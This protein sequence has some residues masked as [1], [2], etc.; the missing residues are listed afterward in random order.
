M[1][2]QPASNAPEYSV[3][4]I[5]SA[6]KRTVEDAFG[7]VRV[8]GELGRV[9]RP[10]SGHVYTDLK[11][12]RAVLSA[13]MWKGTASKLTFKPKEGLEVI[14]TGRMTTFQGQSRYQLVIDRIEPAGVGALMKLLE[15][16]RRKLAAEGLFDDARKRDLPFL[17]KVIG[18]VTSPTG[19]VIRDILHRLSDRTPAHVLVWPVRVQG[20]T[21]AAEVTRAIDGFNAL[22]PGGAIPRPDVL[23]VARGGGS[24]ED[25]WGFNEENV[26]RA[27]AASEIPLVSAVGHETDWTLI[28]YAADVRAPTPTGAAEMVVPVRADLVLTVDDLARRLTA[29]AL[30]GLE[31]RRR[32]LRIAARALP[33]AETLLT[34]PRQRLDQATLRL[35]QALES[36]TLRQRSRFDR[37]ASRLTPRLVVA[38]IKER[39]RKAK[40][41][42]DRLDRAQRTLRDR[43]AERLRALSARVTPRA[44]ERLSAQGNRQLVQ[45]DGRRERAW[46]S[47]LQMRGDRLTQSA[48]LL[49][50][51]NYRRVLDR[52]FALVR[53]QEG[54]PLRSVAQLDAAAQVSIEMADGRR[55][56]AVGGAPKTE[57]PAKKAKRVTDARPVPKQENLFD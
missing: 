40:L 52:G 39:D 9:S 19:A 14:A 34:T 54:A 5:S 2:E 11:D 4:E 15:E 33:Q 31:G 29:A 17:P 21:S 20:E 12:D 13:V 7:Y 22:A 44:I 10:A 38:D 57:K 49:D 32:D 55:D 30:R 56:A 46:L 42:A 8:R 18:V 53:D 25:L 47:S 35:S 50:A 48:K 37:V 24:L 3:S 16:R 43:K 27:A 45:L 28:D 1:D 6:V 23:I 41:A 51:F 36:G 26:A